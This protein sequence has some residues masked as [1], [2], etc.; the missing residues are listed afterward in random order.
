[1]VKP[2]LYLKCALIDTGTW[3]LDRETDGRTDRQNYRS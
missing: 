3:H 1:M 2:S